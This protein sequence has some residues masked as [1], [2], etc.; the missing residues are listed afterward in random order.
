MEKYFKYVVHYIYKQPGKAVKSEVTK[1][2]DDTA[3]LRTVKTEANCEK[4]QKDAV[5]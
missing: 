2:A 4:L 3:L 5:N 1:F